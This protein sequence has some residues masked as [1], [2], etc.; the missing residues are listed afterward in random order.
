LVAGEYR[1]L[2]IGGDEKPETNFDPPA[3]GNNFTQ[4]LRITT[5]R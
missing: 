4:W 3:G 5:E 2:L 1:Q